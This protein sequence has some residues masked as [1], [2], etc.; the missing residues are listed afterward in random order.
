MVFVATVKKCLCNPEE[1]HWV[2]KEKDSKSEGLIRRKEGLMQVR[3]GQEKIICV[4]V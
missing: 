4:F 1:I 2:T 3:E